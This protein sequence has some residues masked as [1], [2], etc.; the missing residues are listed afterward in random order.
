[1]RETRQEEAYFLPLAILSSRWMCLMYWTEVWP[2]Y[3]LRSSFSYL[4]L[5]YV[6]LTAC[7]AFFSGPVRF[8]RGLRWGVVTVTVLKS[9]TLSLLV[10]STV[11]KDSQGMFITSHYIFPSCVSAGLEHAFRIA[12]LLFCYNY[13]YARLYSVQIIRFKTNVTNGGSRGGRNTC[14]HFLHQ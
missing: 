3:W 12:S 7:V 11:S 6:Y 4:G 9:W 10:P 14:N 2:N 1:M 8:T 5:G 13:M